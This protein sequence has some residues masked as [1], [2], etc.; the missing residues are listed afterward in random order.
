MMILLRQLN[1]MCEDKDC[2]CES[3]SIAVTDSMGR[4]KF[5]EDIGRPND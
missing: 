2:N 4:E 1:N 3:K 5:W